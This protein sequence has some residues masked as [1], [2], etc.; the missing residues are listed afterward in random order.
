MLRG[1][2]ATMLLILS[3]SPAFGKFGVDKIEACYGTLGPV[4]KTL[5][6]Y[7]YDELVFR[8][9]VTGAKADDGTLDV[10]C[11]WRL[12]DDK[13]KEVKSDKLPFKGS[14]PFGID[15]LGYSLGF[16]LPDTAR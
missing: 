15:S 3:V 7:P 5:D 2:L 6:F 16:F 11:T 4:R 9:T 10:V 1:L 12:L 8:F 13:G 14:M